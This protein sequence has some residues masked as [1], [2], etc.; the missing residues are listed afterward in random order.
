MTAEINYTYVVLYPEYKGAV[1]H[2]HFLA[3]YQLIAL[4]RFYF[5]CQIFTQ[6]WMLECFPTKI[7]FRLHSHYSSTVPKY[8]IHTH[9]FGISIKRNSDYGKW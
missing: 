3:R 8:G 5:F 1:M 7:S 4:Q 2:L 6:N 9:L